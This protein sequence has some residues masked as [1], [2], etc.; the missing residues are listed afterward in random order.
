MSDTSNFAA[1]DLL[2]RELEDIQD[3]AGFEVPPP[4]DYILRMNTEMKDING[5]D[6]VAPQFEVLDTV[7]L[8]K[9]DVDK[10]V[11]NGTKFSTLFMLDGN[12]ENVEMT[13]SGLKM[14]AADFADAAGTTNLKKLV[15]WMLAAK[16]VTITATVS[17]RKDKNDPDRYYANVKNVTVQG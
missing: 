9:P 17:R 5:V 11:V 8:N 13:I 12:N 7:K 3:L 14:F 4:G 10:P 1:L 6:S 16:D 2:D 15:E